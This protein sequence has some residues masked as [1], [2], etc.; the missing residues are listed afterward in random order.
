VGWEESGTSSIHYCIS[1][2]AW[3]HDHPA[4]YLQGKLRLN[5]DDPVAVNE[6]IPHSWWLADESCKY[7]L[8]VLVHKDNK[9]LSTRLAKQTPG[10]TREAVREK[11]TKETAKERSAAK[12]QRPIRIVQPDGTV[13]VEKYGD[14]DHQSKKAKVDGMRSVI[15]KNR[16]DAIMSQ[17]SVMRGLEEVYVGRMGRDEY[18][19][20]L[21]NLANQMPGM[22]EQTPQGDDLFTPWYLFNPWSGVEWDDD[23]GDE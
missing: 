14:V 3:T 12:A 7:I 20:W 21:V 10:P 1:C 18:E 22:M 2:I 23:D 15:D 8:S 4:H 19:R 6:E 17:I 16:V 11:K 9:D 5:Y 13:A